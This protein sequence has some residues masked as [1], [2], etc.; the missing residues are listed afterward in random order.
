[1]NNYLFAPSSKT[2][3]MFYQQQDLCQNLKSLYWRPRLEEKSF[4]SHLIVDILGLKENSKPRRDFDGKKTR[5][6]FTAEQVCR[7]ES[8]FIMKKYLSSREREELADELGLSQQQVK[9]LHT[10]YIYNLYGNLGQNL[11]PKQKN[12]MEENGK[13]K[14]RRSSKNHEKKAGRW[15]IF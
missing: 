10:D 3:W 12:K 2:T 7:L 15:E 13:C 9:I 11:V 14:Q 8:D 1:M 5:T 4:T 6:C